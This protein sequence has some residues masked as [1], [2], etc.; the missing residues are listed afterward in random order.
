MQFTVTDE[1]GF[2]PN[3]LPTN[4]NPTLNGNFP[5][6]PTPAIQR[7][8]TLVAVQGQNGT[9]TMLLDGQKWAAPV[10]ETPQLG[11]TEDWT[12]INPTMDAHPIHIHLVQFQIVR[13]Q[14]F[15]VGPYLA[16]WASL[17]GDPP[18]DHPTVNVP[19]FDPYFLGTPASLSPSEQA[20]KDT[21]TVNSGEAVVIRLRWTEQNGNPFPFDATAGPGYVWH[22]HLLEHEDNE[23]MRPYVVV[24]ASQNVMLELV[25]IAVIIV[26][27]VVLFVFLAIRR[28]RRRRQITSKRHSGTVL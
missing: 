25:A 7:L 5:T 26:V 3:T 9:A 27:I 8:F 16:E 20:W 10:S 24:S 19:N 6:L 18:F 17:N 4:L 14:T 11:S 21:V 15:K 23:M 13:R 12:I 22:C 1:K 2:T 28:T